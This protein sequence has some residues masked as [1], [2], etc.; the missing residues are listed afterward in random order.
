[1]SNK[2]RSGLYATTPIRLILLGITIYALGSYL[3]L[4]LRLVGNLSEVDTA[5]LT[6]SVFSAAQ[7]GSLLNADQPYGNGMTYP[8]ITLFIHEVSSISI[9]N[10]QAY[11]FLLMSAS[12][13]II[14][15][16][17]YRTLTS[18]N[19]IALLATML[20]FLQPDFLWVT[21]RGSHEK[22]TWALMLLMLT[23]LTKSFTSRSSI[24]TLTRYVILFYIMAFAFVSSN[25]FFAASFIN[26]LALSFIG[27]SIL[28][29]FYGFKN[30][31]VSSY[32]RQHVRRLFYLVASC[33]LILYIF[34][35]HIYPPA[36]SSFL[37]LQ[38]LANQLSLLFLNFEIAVDPYSYISATWINS[39]VYFALTIFNWII[40]LVAALIWLR[41][42]PGYLQQKQM[43]EDELP[44][45]FLWLIFPAFA[46]Q[47]I[48]SMLI[49]R[50]GALGANLQVRLFT[51]MMLLAIPLAAIGIQ[52]MLLYA[53]RTRNLRRIVIGLYAVAIIL[54]S[55][56]AH[57]KASNEPLLSN[58]WT[59][60]TFAER[61]AGAW[62]IQHTQS[63]TV[64]VGLDERL[65][66]AMN[67]HYPDVSL[68]IF[69]GFTPDPDTR[70]YLLSEI[71]RARWI[72]QGRPLLF[73][74]DENLVYDNGSVQVYHRRPRT[75]FQR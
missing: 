6:R 27:G 13:P 7:S 39:R 16:I 63:E 68:G 36:I 35:F 72:R 73:M 60:S 48:I 74:G 34:V 23:F 66:E 62:T 44:Q 15:F 24:G 40:L 67:F 4:A 71:E 47:F 49:D 30:S 12:L 61:L 45:L 21:W 51:P 20:T 70:Y 54:F 43:N 29:M 58:K 69:D 25:T 33:T 37:A 42:L 22:V 59:F 46:L 52:N 2:M 18:S 41:A 55:L 57:M 32:V 53:K 26:A 9:Q 19:S 11:I 31:A 38:G 17:T 1:M 65:V 28:I 5:L 75:P 64:W 14:L 56:S 10:L 50:A 3:Y 8:A